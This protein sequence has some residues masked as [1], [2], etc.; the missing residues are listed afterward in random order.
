MCLQEL[1]QYDVNKAMDAHE[2]VQY[3]WVARSA[4][5]GWEFQDQCAYRGLLPAGKG[6]RHSFSLTSTPFP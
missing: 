3:Q 5:S 6:K 4:A 2:G 1:S